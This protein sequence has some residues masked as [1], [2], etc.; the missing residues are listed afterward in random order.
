MIKN[1][2]QMYLVIGAFALVLLLG[3]TTYAFFNYTRTGV[4][5][6]IRVGRIYFNSNQT[7]TINLDNLFPIDPTEQGIMN[8]STKV[9]TFELEITGDTDY[10][11]GIE[12]LVSSV[13]SN[14]YTSTGKIV[15][16]SLNVEVTELGTPNANYF[17]ARDNTNESIYKKIVG[18]T[19]V[20]DQMLLVGYI[21][22]NTT[23]GQAAGIDGSITIK[24]Y[25]DKNNILISD[26]YDGSESDNMGT[27]NSKAQG[28]TVITTG[29]WNALQN[30]GVSF[31]VKVEANEGIWVNGSLE[32]IMR[33]TV[34]MDNV[35]STY[36]SAQSGIDFGAVSSDTNGKGVYMRAGTE[37]DDYPIMYYRGD[38]TDNN[39]VFA[40]QCWKAVRTT[41]TGGV[42]LI[43]NG[44]AKYDNSPISQ[45]S[46]TIVTN[47]STSPFT[48]DESDN[49]WNT[50]ITDSSGTEI[51]FNVPAGSGYKFIM[52]GT[53]GSSTG[54]A[55]YI[56]K[57]DTKVYESGGG[58]GQ[59]LSATQDFGTLTASNVIKFTYSGSG[60]SESPIT[61]KIRM[62]KPNEELGLKCE[63]TGNGT[64]ISVDV[65]GT[66]TNMFTFNTNYNSP[67]YNGYMYGTVY[68]YS[69]SNW[70]SNAKFGSSF[71]WDGTNYKLVDASVTE[72][73][74]THHYSC[75]QVD[76]D[77]TCTDLRHV[78]YYSGSAK[79]YV[80]L[81]GGDGIEDA[82]RKTQTNTTDSNA[83]D[84][85]DTWYASNLTN[86]TNKLEDTVW[87]ND[88]S[89]GDNNNNGWI[90]NGGDLTTV[91]SYGA[92]ER[93]NYA[94]NTSTVKNQPSLACTNKNDRF[95]VNNGNGNQALQYPTALLTEDEIVLAGGVVGAT[96]SS[97]Y[98]KSGAYWWSLSPSYFDGNSAYEFYLSGNGSLSN[99]SVNPSYGLRP[100]I[101][102][103][104]GT[105]VVSGTGTV[106]DPYIIG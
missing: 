25:L 64:L 37:S 47:S 59:T 56:Y 2:K 20:G 39:V 75:N 85:I 78:N 22:P 52:T 4:S 13:D 76:A 81:T 16:I 48:F 1:K 38:V 94:Q 105:P 102:L 74:A 93:S 86:Y 24:A 68:T 79:Y 28:K 34:V 26:T 100:S 21:V 15:P 35:S 49:T 12:Y 72:P 83:K 77:A 50:I 7:N 23:T 87:C 98:L 31:K 71:T 51:S 36:V 84:K 80:T 58:G 41:D 61:F 5:N 97:F 62:E 14:I 8:D 63:S 101:S 3:T 92:R 42:K 60:T 95:T 69:S 91:L 30:S 70:T 32:E 54:G 10:S 55:Y 89:V 106:T 73:N 11:E 99:I 33:K 27:T 44:E 57:D 65:N 96:N 45:S 40:N 43:Y 90:S 9:G 19:L 88:R 82:L 29:E 66:P 17:T 6:N 67:A 103:K 18:D 104:P 46:Y 53:T